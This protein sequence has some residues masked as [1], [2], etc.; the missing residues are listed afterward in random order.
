MPFQHGAL[1][2]SNS[3]NKEMKYQPFVIPNGSNGFPDPTKDLFI[4]LILIY[5]LFGS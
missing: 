5:I 1:H 4:Y 3:S 2:A